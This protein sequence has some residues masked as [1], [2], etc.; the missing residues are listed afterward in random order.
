VYKNTFQR[1]VS[2]TNTSP[3]QAA[4]A[5]NSVAG[6]LACSGN[7]AVTDAG[8]PNTV[9]GT[10]S[11]QCAAGAQPFTS[12][13]KALASTLQALA[14]IPQAQPATPKAQ[15]ATTQAQAAT[16]GNDPLPQISR[17]AY[18]DPAAF[19]GIGNGSPG[20]LH[21]DWMA[22]LSG[23]EPLNQVSIPGTHDTATY[24]APTT[25]TSSIGRT[26]DMA[27]GDQLNAGI[28]SLDIRVGRR[29]S[30]SC[31]SS[32][33]QV[34][35]FHGTAAG[36]LCLD[37]L[38]VL[39]PAL[40][41]FL[42]QH[43]TEFLVLRL[44]DSGTPNGSWQLPGDACQT[45]SN[46]NAPTWTDSNGTTHNGQPYTSFFYQGGTVNPT[47]QDLR[48]KIYLINDF[49]KD[50]PNDQVTAINGNTDGV[51]TGTTVTS[52]TL[53][54]VSAA[55]PV[56]GQISLPG[57]LNLFPFSAV[58]ES[59]GPVT[60]NVYENGPTGQPYA[61]PVTTTSEG[62]P[63]G[64]I[65]G[66]PDVTS[67]TA[68][69]F[70]SFATEVAHA[71]S[72][73]RFY[74]NLDNNGNPVKTS[75]NWENLQDD[76]DQPN[77]YNIGDKWNS[78]QYEFQQTTAPPMPSTQNQIFMNYLS[79]A[80]DSGSGGY[81]YPCMFASGSEGCHTDSAPR[82]TDLQYGTAE[83]FYW[84][85]T[86]CTNN[87]ASGF[88]GD[89][90]FQCGQM[91]ADGL[92]ELAGC[93]DDAIDH[94]CTAYFEGENNMAE[95]YINGSGFTGSTDHGD[96]NSSTRRPG[97]PG[98]VNRTGIIMADF[99]GVNLIG[100]I[101]ATN[102]KGP[103]VT[104]SF[105]P[106]MVYPG[107]TSTLTI[108]VKNPNSSDPDLPDLSFG[109][110]QFGVHLPQGLIFPPVSPN[111]LGS[112]CTFMDFFSWQL[113]TPNS[114]SMIVEGQE[115]FTG[116]LPGATCTITVP[117][118]ISPNIARP[119]SLAPAQYQ[120]TIDP[121]RAQDFS[122]NSYNGQ[123]AAADLTVVPLL[124]TQSFAP[125]TVIAGQSSTL[126]FQIKDPFPTASLANVGF[127]ALVSPGLTFSGPVTLGG[128]PN[129]C[130][131][132][133][134]IGFPGFPTAQNFYVPQ[135][136][137][138][139]AGL[140]CTV[141][142]QVQS[143]NSTGPGL[144]QSGVRNFT[145]NDQAGETLTGAA[146]NA[147]LTI[148]PLQVTQS[149]A[150]STVIAGQSST[151]TFQITNP[152]PAT[153]LVNVKFVADL[154]PGLTF[155][156]LPAWDPSACEGQSGFIRQGP[157]FVEPGGLLVPGGGTCTI[158]M[159]VQASNGLGQGNYESVVSNLSASDP[160]GDNLVGSASNGAL[161]VNAL[162]EMT[163]TFAPSFI[164]V[165]KISTLTFQ[166]QNPSPT[167]SL[168]NVGF[169]ATVPPGLTFSGPVTLG[170][171]P[172]ACQGPPVIGFPGFPTAQNFFV[173]QDLTVGA[174]LT[175]TV[176]VQVQSSN[177]TG[178]ASSIVSN[179][180]ATDQAGDNLVGTAI[181][182]VL[183]VGC[184]PLSC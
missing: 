39:M 13:T 14:A 60:I 46:G 131:G 114:G 61:F 23:S 72:Y 145:A 56:G 25:G 54:T 88:K 31:S 124:M 174:G 177:S 168:A 43:P 106:S 175:C 24:A 33:G 38:S 36:G 108:K 37:N 149:F 17:M 18:P 68:C 12:P 155:S 115:K 16:P 7:V 166:I 34:W 1:N 165:G 3:A 129:A 47:V 66:Y 181:N 53:A 76:S 139:G 154:P 93:L 74:N 70:S 132:P 134:V 162:L 105:A 143:S 85:D 94:F 182:G 95:A 32:S 73:A 127:T 102:Y 128:D 40:T 138:V 160:A 65:F 158:A 29:D 126:T 92:Y 141:S 89:S 35:M 140:T 100:A 116:F 67:G 171:D 15:A 96:P 86:D 180:T 172:N 118:Q 49:S 27:I 133:P 148:A 45:I 87:G 58:P 159:Q 80:G 42:E 75:V 167:T 90:Y 10:E 103:V 112:D 122:G 170:G 150:P 153:P 79:A 163:Q 101:I 117:I 111:N 78:I 178:Q 107:Q 84:Y 83:F 144:W 62:A 146:D 121:L 142:V 137:T 2:V 20:A 176:S 173:P 120:S 161:S 98:I 113:S 19:S 169:T 51:K 157:E 6:N 136:L 156:G 21:E 52:V 9:H 123:W 5:S 130:Q 41:G 152:S 183:A 55:I 69:D 48:G 57:G 109:K 97:F 99:P 147:D 63:D 59:Q 104:Q 119:N 11:G 135:D 8:I 4:I 28:R 50:G 82:S 91:T 125:S 71:Q 151:L 30:G 22:G 110:V 44:G 164:N 179:F 77:W 26:Q 184:A 81:P 64:E